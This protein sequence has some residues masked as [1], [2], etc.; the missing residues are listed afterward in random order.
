MSN[1]YDELMYC[2]SQY[3]EKW[4]TKEASKCS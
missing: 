2:S 1:N 3:C 4:R